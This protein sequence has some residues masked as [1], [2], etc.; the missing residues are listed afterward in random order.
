MPKSAGDRNI[1]NSIEFF[2]RSNSSSSLEE[3]DVYLYYSNY[4][5]ILQQLAQH[6]NQFSHSHLHYLVIITS[7]SAYLLY[8]IL[9]NKIDI[10]IHDHLTMIITM[11]NIAISPPPPLLSYIIC[12]FFY[13]FFVFPSS[14]VLLFCVLCCIS[15]L[16]FYLFFAPCGVFI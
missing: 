15:F 16:F 4:V 8:F 2:H 10:H 6:G 9:Y 13:F 14:A 7:T 3:K 11:L 1:S 5:G 12:L